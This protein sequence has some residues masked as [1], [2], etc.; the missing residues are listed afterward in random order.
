M[1]QQY[2]RPPTD[3]DAGVVDILVLVDY[4]EQMAHSGIIISVVVHSREGW[5]CDERSE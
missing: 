4:V 3:N 1:N 5:W 2:L